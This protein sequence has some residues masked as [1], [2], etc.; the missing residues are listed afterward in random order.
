MLEYHEI[1]EEKDAKEIIDSIVKIHGIEI[2]HS[3]I[4]N[5]NRKQ[6]KKQVRNNRYIDDAYR[7]YS[8]IQDGKYKKT[9][10]YDEIEN[11]TNRSSLTI[12]NNCAKFD[13]EAYEAD[14]ARIGAFIDNFISREIGNYANYEQ[15]KQSAI[16]KAV[17]VSGK[18]KIFI[19]TVYKKYL[20]DREMG[21]LKIN[22]NKSA[23]DWDYD[24]VMGNN[25]PF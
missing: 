20:F 1:V 7:V 3:Y 11:Q 18:S 17:E 8:L 22:K 4:R 2:L 16:N 5:Y 6:R 10:A 21:R 25:I 15:I 12:R 19:E 9:K 24:T 23:Y 13:K 14:Y